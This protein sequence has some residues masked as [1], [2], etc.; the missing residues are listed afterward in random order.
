MQPDPNCPR[1]L[2][3]LAP[4]GDFFRGLA[5]VRQLNNGRR[6]ARPCFSCPL[7]RLAGHHPGCRGRAHAASPARQGAGRGCRGAEAPARGFGGKARRMSMQRDTPLPR[8]QPAHG[9]SGV[10]RRNA[11]RRGVGRESLTR[12]YRGARLPDCRCNGTR[13]C[14]A[15]NRRTVGLGRGAGTLLV[16]GARGHERPLLGWDATGGRSAALAMLSGASRAARDT[17]AQ[18]AI[19]RAAVFAHA[20]W[21]TTCQIRVEKNRAQ[22]SES[23]SNFRAR[24][25]TG[26]AGCGRIDPAIVARQLAGNRI[27]RP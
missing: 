11:F 16:V 3:V 5:K 2:P 24:R 20:L 27:F 21:L 23:D 9:W 7:P 15:S 19:Y 22:H 25:N 14:R 10:E 13:R 17:R 1:A 8:I 12:G 4:A 26:G 18:L 6:I